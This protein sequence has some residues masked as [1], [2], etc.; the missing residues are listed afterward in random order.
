M[1]AREAKLRAALEANGRAIL[2]YFERRV[3]RDD[4]PDLLAEVMLV[5]WRRIDVVPAEAQQVRMWLF[6]VARNVLAD[7]GRA[8]KR[9]LRLA[10]RLRAVVDVSDAHAAPADEHAEVI[11]A[12]RRLPLGLQ[13]LIALVHWDGFNLTEAADHL[14]VRPSTARGRYQRAR[15]L[16]R[17]ALLVDAVTAAPPSKAVQPAEGGRT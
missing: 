7:H 5:A 17:D 16:L 4:A 10:D 11:D 1:I 3:D 8:Q 2:N 9:R 13:E 14:G 6:G 12:V 15:E